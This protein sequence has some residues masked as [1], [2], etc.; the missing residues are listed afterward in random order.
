MLAPERRPMKTI[1]IVP[2]ICIASITSAIDSEHLTYDDFIR[3][4]E[5]GNIK[6]VKLDKFSSITG[7]MVD[8]DTTKSFKLYADIGTANDPLLNRLLTEH[9]VEISAQD[10]TNPMSGLPMTVVF[11]TGCLSIIIPFVTI[12]LLIV[13]IRKL[14]KSLA[15]QRN[16]LPTDQDDSSWPQS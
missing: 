12:V 16:F 5:A 2:L 11:T 15:N 10:Q 8:G 6:S 1:L 3:Q 7:T 4:V 14:N 9:G 13:I